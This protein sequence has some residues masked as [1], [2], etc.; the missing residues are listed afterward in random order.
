MRTHPGNLVLAILALL[1]GGIVMFLV[2][3]LVRGFCLSVLWAWLIVPV[4]NLPNLSIAQA[5][6]VALV[7]NYFLPTAKEKIGYLAIFGHGF[8]ALA[9]GYLIHLFI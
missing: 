4:F 8:A 3:L 1:T 6:G 9:V 7:L 2:A 5:L